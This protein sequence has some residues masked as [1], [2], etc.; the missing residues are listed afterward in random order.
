M[1]TRYGSFEY[2]VMPF[3]LTNAPATF[4]NLMN[5]VFA[6]YIDRFVNDYVIYSETLEEHAMHLHKVFAKL[7]EESL[8]VKK[9]KCEFSQ[10]TITFLGHVISQRCVHM[11]H[12]KVEA[13][14]DWTEPKNLGEIRS[15][16]GLANYY[17][18]FID[19]YSKKVASLTYLSRKEKSW[20][21]TDEYQRSFDA[22]KEAVSTEPV[23]A[24]LAS[25]YHLKCTLILQAGI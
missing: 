4:C 11:D 23:F 20:A 8:Y 25:I 10:T 7:R 3:G 19:G 18:R 15:F 9:E 6:E 2:R 14:M 24:C 16:L 21:W 12:K 13:I 17:R 1:V 5:Y 22:L